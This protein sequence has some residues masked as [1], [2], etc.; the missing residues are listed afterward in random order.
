MVVVDEVVV[1]VVAVVEMVVVHMVM[2]VVVV[3]EVNL[4]SEVVMKDEVGVTACA[5]QT[6]PCKSRTARHQ[7]AR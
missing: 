6:P 4:V 7:Q 3:V 5:V 2:I 1:V